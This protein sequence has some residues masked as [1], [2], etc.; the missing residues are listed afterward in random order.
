MAFH[1]STVQKREKRIKSRHADEKGE[2]D[3]S[4]TL[5]TANARQWWLSLNLPSP[6]LLVVGADSTMGEVRTQINDLFNGISLSHSE[7]LF[8][9]SPYLHLCSGS[10]TIF[11][12][13]HPSLP[14]LTPPSIQKGAG[15]KLWCCL[16]LLP[17]SPSCKFWHLFWGLSWLFA[18]HTS[19]FYI[20]HNGTVTSCMFSKQIR[21]R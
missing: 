20:H 1:S 21:S 18:F 13:F 10:L 9:P 8:L 15:I 16:L 6:C 12:L 3:S 5:A 11:P 7:E 17:Y 14:H 4:A 2:R 19:L